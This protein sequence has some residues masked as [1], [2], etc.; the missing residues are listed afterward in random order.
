MIYPF[1]I[2]YLFMCVNVRMSVVVFL[3][4]SECVYVYVSI[5]VGIYMPW[6][7]CRGQIRTLWNLFLFFNLCVDCQDWTLVISLL[8]K[9]SYLLHHLAVFITF[10]NPQHSSYTVLTKTESV[11]QIRYIWFLRVWS[12]IHES[13]N[14]PRDSSLLQLIE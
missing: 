2:T 8:R 10:H 4:S 5:Y 3:C 14:F 7:D 13:L 12:P 1:K 6:H 9:N 11:K